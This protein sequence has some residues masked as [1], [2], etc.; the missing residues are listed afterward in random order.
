MEKIL[1]V[2]SSTFSNILLGV[3]WF[4]TLMVFWIFR[5]PVVMGDGY[6]IAQ[7]IN[8]TRYFSFRWYLA[9]QIVLSVHRTFGVILS[10]SSLQSLQLTSAIAGA[11]TIIF[12]IKIIEHLFIERYKRWLFIGLL[13]SA[14]G[15]IQLWFGYAEIYPVVAL[16]WTILIWI[17]LL[18]LDRKLS[19]VWGSIFSGIVYVLYI[20]NIFLFP[21]YIFIV[22]LAVRRLCSW[23]MRVKALILNSL[24]LLGAVALC[25]SLKLGM[26]FE[27]FWKVQ[28]ASVNVTGG[29]ASASI[30]YSFDTLISWH[31]VREFI[32]EWAL[33]DASGFLLTV[34][35]PLFWVLSRYQKWSLHRDLRVYLF[36]MIALPYV[37]YSY[38]MEPLLGYP[39]DWDLFSYLGLFT[40]LL[41]F[42]MFV[43]YHNRIYIF[44]RLYVILA[45]SG[46]LHLLLTLP[47]LL[48]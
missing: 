2:K 48:F 36:A 19:L 7:K 41:G 28:R 43:E 27:R 21:V 9:Y 40:S 12:L 26:D 13:P 33:V 8:D 5:T 17:Y 15:P 3:I 46:W 37:A 38:L 30:F 34:L 42:Y 29:T 22:L 20:G 18:I 24:T 25:L 11:T 39:Q 1:G 44:D 4:T 31:H 6:Y 32:N 35:A 14:Y 16:G 47:S 10:L 23:P 45:T